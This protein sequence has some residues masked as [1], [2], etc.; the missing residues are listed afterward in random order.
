MREDQNVFVKLCA[1]R[2]LRGE[3]YLI[4]SYSAREILHAPE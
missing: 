4:I 2:V 3:S 1:L